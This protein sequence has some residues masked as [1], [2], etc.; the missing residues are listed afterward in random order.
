MASQVEKTKAQG[1]YT[2][3]VM[4]RGNDDYST[5]HP[6]NSDSQQKH[7]NAPYNRHN[8][9]SDRNVY[10]FSKSILYRITL[11]L[12]LLNNFIYLKKEQSLQSV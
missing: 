4:S 6:H 2:L 12:Y 7:L 8:D 11:H 1:T 5:V 10:A 9:C 3:R